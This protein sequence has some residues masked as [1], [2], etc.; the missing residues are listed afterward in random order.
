[1]RGAR[2]IV[3]AFT[4]ICALVPVAPAA[5]AAG[6]RCFGRSATIVGTP[7]P[8]VLVGTA[9]PDVVVALGGRDVIRGLGRRD[10]ICGGAGSDSIDG[11]SGPDKVLAGSGDDSVSGGRGADLLL[12]EERNDTLSGGPGR[13]G[14][15]GNGGADVLDGERGRDTLLY[16]LAHGPV[17]VNL[18]LR[19]ATG[20]GHDVVTRSENVVGSSY[21]DV[22]IGNAKRNRL[23]GGMGSGE[24]LLVGRAGPDVLFG[25][26]GDDDLFGGPGNDLLDDS[27]AHAEGVFPDTGADSLIGGSGDDRL[28]ARDDVNGNDTLD[29]RLGTD[30][31][32]ADPA[33]SIANCEG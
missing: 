25:G 6:P 4:S 27:L 29:G 19:T 7:G 17:V 10:L 24:D 12:G 11:G 30:T 5:E 32:R 23:D 2:P 33:D 14:L 31:C 26:R 13:D 16:F 21:G 18:T 1:V 20:E 22:L 15:A 9:G 28:K 3:A 8:D